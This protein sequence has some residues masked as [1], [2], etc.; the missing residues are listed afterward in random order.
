LVCSSWQGTLPRDHGCFKA[1]LFRNETV[2]RCVRKPAACLAC[3]YALTW[4]ER[5]HRTHEL[6]CCVG[7]LPPVATCC[8]DVSTHPAAAGQRSAACRRCGARGS[9]PPEGPADPCYAAQHHRCD[10]PGA[11]DADGQHRVVLF[12]LAAGMGTGRGGYLSHVCKCHSEGWC[13]SEPCNIHHQCAVC[14]AVCQGDVIER[15][16]SGSRPPL[17]K[18]CTRQPRSNHRIGW[19]RGSCQSEHGHISPCDKEACCDLF[20]E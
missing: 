18:Y 19:V 10:A 20:R 13:R 11:H 17:R 7:L 9:R 1:V 15:H 12:Y 2:Q 16:K 5:G 14:L 8:G 3:G 6:W 4:R